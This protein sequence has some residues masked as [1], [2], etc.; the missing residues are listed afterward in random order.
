[1]TEAEKRAKAAKA[2]AAAAAKA[3]A[4]AAAKA[5]AA[6]AKKLADEKSAEQ[7]A[8]TAAEKA[9]ETVRAQDRA[10]RWNTSR[11]ALQGVLGT[12]F[13]INDPE[14]KAWINEFYDLAK[15]LSD[16]GLSPDSIPEQIL[17]SGKAP[18]K[19]AER[20]SGALE[21]QRKKLAGENV[22]VP[23]I[24][25]YVAGEEEYMGLVKSFGMND[26]AS[27]QTYGKITGNAVSVNE[28]R[29][30]I[31]D[32]VS[33]VDSL[34]QNVKD[35]LKSEFP[36][37]KES[38]MAQAILTGP[39]GIQNLKTK[40]Q[41]AGVKAGAAAAGLTMQTS[42]DQ[43]GNLSYEQATAGFQ[44]V[45]NTLKTSTA[46][47]Q[48]AGRMFGD[49]ISATDY[50]TELEKETLL[51]QTSQ[52]TK[53]LQSQARSQFAGQSGIVTGSLSRKKQI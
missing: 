36:T 10:D 8:I 48:Q 21:L 9:A 44:Q 45:A 25:E 46:G 29:K 37:L 28:T 30:R 15:P 3:K 22:Y 47:I 40:I 5:K 38:D 52:R 41:R 7:A 11:E 32:A 39:D 27:K 49:E 26:L 33:R 19:F 53:R 17:Y 43:L 1:M 35:Q 4:A 13:N 16:V 24:A 18:K 50:Q 34:D 23:S 12:M 31:Q 20:F 6:A 51:G 14:E 42:L 2:K